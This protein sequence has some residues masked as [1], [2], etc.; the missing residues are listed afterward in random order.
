MKR[1][2]VAGA[3]ALMLGG[4]GNRLEDYRGQEPA[5]MLSHF[6]DG[7][8]VAHGL[9]LDRSGRVGSRFRVEMQGEWRE[10]KG[11]LFEQFFFDDGRKETRTWWLEQAADGSWRGRAGDVVGEARGQ[12]EGFA[13][14]WRYRLNLR[15]PD[16]ERVRVDFDDWMYLLDERR[17]I[18]RAE[19]RKFGIKLGEV[20]LY[21]EKTDSQK[22][23]SS[24]AAT[25]IPPLPE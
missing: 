21:I 25:I 11:C 23:S 5:W 18:N 19:I 17:L 12:S 22:L 4:C 10:G 6:F 1:W 2:I 9:V 24:Q 3:M 20:L 14:N 7:P 8:L 13:L 16:G 15:L